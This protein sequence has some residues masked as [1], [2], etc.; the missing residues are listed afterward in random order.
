MGYHLS[1]HGL[2]A[3]EEIASLKDV[4]GEM[5]QAVESAKARNSRGIAGKKLPEL[6]AS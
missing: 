4:M 3:A 1:G 5:R 6:E 2:S